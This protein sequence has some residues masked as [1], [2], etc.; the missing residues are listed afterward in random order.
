MS[1]EISAFRATRLDLSF[2]AGRLRVEFSRRGDKDMV[3][4]T[5]LLTGGRGE[6][7]EV[8]GR[9]PDPEVDDPEH[10]QACS[11]ALL[12]AETALED[13]A[14]DLRSLA[15]DMRAWPPSVTK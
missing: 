12:A 6:G 14:A 11:K 9:F 5:A 15:N 1:A 4:W 13:V 2:R 7:F 8:E 10:G 3:E